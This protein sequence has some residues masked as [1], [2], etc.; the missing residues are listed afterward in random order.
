MV[1]ENA[2]PVTET[3]GEVAISIA[4]YTLVYTQVCYHIFSRNHAKPNEL[5]AFE[6][7]TM[8]RR[9]LLVVITNTTEAIIQLL[10]TTIPYL[11]VESMCRIIA[12][13]IAK[14]W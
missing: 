13:G 1:S 2:T 3:E 7:M 5:E 4:P 8:T 6:Q 12:S 11:T 14:S 9:K 10:T